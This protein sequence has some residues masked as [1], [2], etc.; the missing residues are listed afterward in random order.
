MVTICVGRDGSKRTLICSSSASPSS[1]P[2]RILEKIGVS[3]EPAGLQSHTANTCGSP[4]SPSGAGSES[5][6]R[7]LP[8]ADMSIACTPC[9]CGV[10][11]VLTG[12]AQHESQTKSLESAPRS[13]VAICRRS[14]LE[15]AH[16]IGLQ[17]PCNSCWLFEFTS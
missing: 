17:C 6:T 2:V 12:C 7:Y 9:G 13:D 4:D 3:V 14:A 5:V 11:I 15:H 16:V 1:S 10:A 8:S